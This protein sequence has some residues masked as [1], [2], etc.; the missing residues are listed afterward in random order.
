MVLDIRYAHSGDVSI[1]Y[2]SIGDGPV[3]LVYVLGA[4]T[5]LEV[6]WELPAYRRYC[7][8]LA[9]FSRILL[10]DK[11]GMG[12]SERVP[13][14]TPLETR[15][16]DI[17][18][19]M[20]AAGSETAVLMGESEGG[21]LSIMFAA[22]HPERTKALVLQGAEVRERKDEDWPW[23]EASTEEFEAVMSSLPERWGEGKGI[24]NL[25]PSV[26]DQPWAQTWMGRLQQ[27]AATPAGAEGFMRMAFE[28]DARSIVP[29]VQVPC[30]VLHAADDRI[31][32]VENG[33]FFASTLPNVRYVELASSDHVRWFEPDR[34]IAEISEFLTGRREDPTPDRILAAILFTDIVDS[35]RHA[36]KLGDQV[37]R[38]LLQSHFEAA[39]RDVARFAG[40]EITTTGDGI[41]PSSTDPP[42]PSAVPSQSSSRHD[43][44]GSKCAPA[45]TPAKSR[46]WATT[47]QASRCT[48]PRGSPRWRDRV[49]SGCRERSASW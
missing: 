11:R 23:G 34:A 42:A 37:W 10:F 6:M 7:E 25:V 27:N 29:A 44:W 47:W 8:R 9:E 35:T 3:D 15:M 36:A 12:M 13:G 40:S 14:A 5:H 41:W 17:G 19:V 45:S 46:R 22:A 38:E 24:A 31:C 20:D 2:A 48:S 30:L 21:P 18:A 28:I 39:R 16:D 32:H 49:R 43:R 4:Y 26:G 1:A 33:R